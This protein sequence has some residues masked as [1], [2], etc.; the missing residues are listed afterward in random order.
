MSMKNLLIAFSV[1]IIVGLLFWAPW[2][3]SDGGEDLIESDFFRPAKTSQSQQDLFQ[4][5]KADCDCDGSCID[6]HWAPFGAIVD[7]CSY[8]YYYVTFW[9]QHIYRSGTAEPEL[10][11]SR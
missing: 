2:V 5:L 7:S 10:S 1:I 8:D 4:H 11:T 6:V 9:G 3:M